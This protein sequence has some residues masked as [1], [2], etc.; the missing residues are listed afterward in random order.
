MSQGTDLSNFGQVPQVE[1]VMALGRSRQQ[2]SADS[3]VSLHSRDHNGVA[4]R[5][6]LGGPVC[7]EAPQDG[8]QDGFG[9]GV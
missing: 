9:G 3:V 2:F 5:P 6:Y 8:G 1:G 7:Q 4:Q